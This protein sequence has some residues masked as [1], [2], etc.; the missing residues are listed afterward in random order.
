MFIIRPEKKF[1]EPIDCITRW[2]HENAL[3]GLEQIEQVIF[4]QFISYVL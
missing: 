3:L 1:V 4:C 2:N